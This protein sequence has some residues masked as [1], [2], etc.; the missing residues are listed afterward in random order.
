MAG[1]DRERQLFCGGGNHWRSA[2]TIA[3]RGGFC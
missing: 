1:Q 2:A 3:G